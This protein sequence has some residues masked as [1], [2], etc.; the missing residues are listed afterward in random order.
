MAS[1]KSSGMTAAEFGE[2][3]DVN[4]RT[5]TLVGPTIVLAFVVTSLAETAARRRG[6]HWCAFTASADHT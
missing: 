6:P 2:A 5:L 3:R 4:P 1:W